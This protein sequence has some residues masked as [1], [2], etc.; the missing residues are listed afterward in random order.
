MDNSLEEPCAG[1]L[2][3]NK[4]NIS[5]K[6]KT[7]HHRMGNGGYRE[8]IYTEKY[9]KILE[10]DLFA[11]AYRLFYEDSSPIFMKVCRQMQIN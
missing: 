2:G 3:A 5:C 1:V 11:S 10:V 6:T 4:E 9:T 7:M 8:D